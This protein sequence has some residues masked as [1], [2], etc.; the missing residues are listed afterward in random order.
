M[1]IAKK[2][3]KTS[4]K[5]KKTMS[6]KE[7]RILIVLS[8]VLALAII[9]VSIFVLYPKLSGRPDWQIMSAL[10]FNNDTW[11]EEMVD[12]RIK[13]TEKA[14]DINS[15]FVYSKDTAFITA[16]YASS[17]NINDARK[18]FLS[19]I[20]GAVDYSTDV[21]SSINITGMLR[22][23]EE[24]N[25]VNYEA[26]VLNA[27]DIKIILEK[28]KAEAIK[29]KLIEEF[30]AEVLYKL[31]EIAGIMKCEK[32][33]GYVMYDDDELSNTSYPGVPIFSE[34]YRYNGAQAELVEIQ[35]AIKEKYTTSIYL[36]QIGTVYFKKMGYIF[37]LNVSE[38]DN[39]ILAVITA[40]KIPDSQ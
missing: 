25:I 7:K 9:L 36:E 22:K 38:S 33:G 27:F 6:G 2:E 17:S 30:P 11:I 4:G 14:I 12:N 34:A 19:A 18:Y 35:K 16:M 28:D 23:E 40:Q 5:L 37:S 24:I 26:D 1:P 10:D 15:S 13:P 8:S 20:P 32:L 39:N 31:P 21:D 3:T 29:K